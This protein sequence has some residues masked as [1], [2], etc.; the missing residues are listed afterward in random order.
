MLGGRLLLW[1]PGLGLGK[2]RAHLILPYNGWRER[3]PLSPGSCGFPWTASCLPPWG[4]PSSSF[5]IGVAW[6]VSL[7]LRRPSLLACQGPGA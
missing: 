1:G 5:L 3:H 4:G 7:L 6:P 2:E